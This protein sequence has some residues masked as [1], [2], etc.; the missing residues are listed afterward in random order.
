MLRKAVLTLQ[1]LNI[2]TKQLLN[3][4]ITFKDDFLLGSRITLI[5]CI[6][7][8]KESNRARVVVVVGVIYHAGG[9]DDVLYDLVF[10]RPTNPVPLKPSSIELPVGMSKKVVSVD[11]S[12]VFK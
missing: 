6:I 11:G 1:T 4:L 9:V 2:A 12:S 7:I 8:Y 10:H 5:A 3:E